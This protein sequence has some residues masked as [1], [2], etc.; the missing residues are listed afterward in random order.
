[1]AKESSVANILSATLGNAPF[2]PI[3]SMPESILSSLPILRLDGRTLS[4]TRELVASIAALLLPTIHVAN[5]GVV[6]QTLTALLVQAPVPDDAVLGFALAVYCNQT[7][8]KRSVDGA[9]AF[10]QDNFIRSRL[11]DNLTTEIRK[12]LSSHTGQDATSQSVSVE[13]SVEQ[14]HVPDNSD[15]NEKLLDDWANG[16]L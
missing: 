8:N 7:P 2:L 5:H 9:F 13:S 1:M 12:Y 3:A 11:T 4:W 15:E 10:L 14:T 6:P 16:V